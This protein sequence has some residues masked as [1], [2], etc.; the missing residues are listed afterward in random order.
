MLIQ[1]TSG[2]I[3]NRNIVYVSVR[4]GYNTR[5]IN[6]SKN[7]NRGQTVI[8]RYQNTFRY[9]TSLFRRPMSPPT[10]RSNSYQTTVPTNGTDRK[11]HCW[12]MFTSFFRFRVRLLFLPDV[13]CVPSRR[14]TVFSAAPFGFQTRSRRT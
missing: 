2:P 4:T 3:P 8:N 11:L 7:R 6:I 13:P 9:C 12:R 5:R 14:L 10:P 1:R